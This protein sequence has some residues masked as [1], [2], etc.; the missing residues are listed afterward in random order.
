MRRIRLAL[1]VAAAALIAA[2]APV[3]AISPQRISAQSDSPSA[4]ATVDTAYALVQLRGAPLST[5]VKTKPA[6]GKKIDFN[7]GATKALRA[8]LSALRND[9]K[10]WLR[11]NAP[12]A[13][14]TGS[15]DISLNA[16]SVKLNG[17]SLDQLAI[18]PQVTHVEYEGLYHPDVA[19]VDPDLTLINAL[20]AWTQ[21]GGNANAGK[22]VKVAIVDT[23]IDVSNPCF[24]DTDFPTTTQLGDNHFTNNKVIVAKV[25][26]NKT[27]SRGY[28]AAPVQ[29][30]GTH[31]AGTV[32]CDFNTAATVSG[33]SIPYGISGV[34]PAAQLGNYN[35]F[36]GDVTNARSE[37]ILNALE[38]AYLD[39]MGVANLSLGGGAHGIQDLLTIAVDNLDLAH[40]VV[41]V[42]AGNSGDGEPAAHPPLPAGHYTVESPGSAARALTAGAFTVGHSVRS[43]VKQGTTY[44]ASEDGEFAVPSV[45]LTGMT[46]QALGGS[47]AELVDGHLDGCTTYSSSVTD[48]LVLVARGVCTFAE[49][50]YFAQAAGAAGVIIVNRDPTPIPMADDPA[51]GNTIPAVMV[52]LADGLALYA[53]IPTNATI[54][55]PL[56]VSLDDP[57]TAAFAPEKNVQSSFSSQG[58]TDVDFRVK[59]DV[60]APGENV[61]SSIPA[62]F[63][64]SPPCFAFFAGTSMATPHLAG[65]AAVVK[66]AHPTWDAWQIRSAIVNTADQD[67]IKS[68]TDGTTIVTDVNIVGAGRENLFSAVKASVF[69]DPV[70]VSF[71]AVPSRSGQTKT[72]ALAVTNTA[73]TAAT[74]SIVGSG[75]GIAFRVSPA[76]VE[77]G[78]TATVTVTATFDKAA[79]AGDHQAQLNI[80]V[81][82]AQVAHAAVYAFVK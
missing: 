80:T 53:S 27:P 61:L 56:Y 65:S 77:A 2:A 33:A 5:D 31:V 8:Q 79:A 59:P 28:S 35:I 48:K 9:F 57:L 15:W 24:K 43:L 51:L 63:C 10:Q 74:L 12:K 55:A 45:D 1:A 64:A 41:A 73:A 52:G 70:S 37:D 54:T 30:H 46:V 29:E 16:V 3:G 60:M 32:A 67:V 19:T 78:A 75:T 72:F 38:A 23:G 14:V 82:T 11:T 39:D 7:N 17:T 42:A 81:G 40:M 22:G 4:G 13:Q 34:A 44:Y 76:S 71:G 26:S 6:P 25:F 58:P 18:A 62:A 21:V 20:N 68:A 47:P 50:V 36:P 66:G 69:L 49:K